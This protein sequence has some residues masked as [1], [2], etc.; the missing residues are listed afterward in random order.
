MF[1]CLH[2]EAPPYLVEL[3]QPVAGVASRQHIRSATRQLLVVPRH[4]L[5]FYG[6]RTFCVAGLSVWNSPPDSLRNPFIIGG[7]SFRQSLKTFLFTTYWYIQRNRGFTTICY[8]NLLFLLTY[9]DENGF[10]VFNGGWNDLLSI[11]SD[12]TKNYRVFRQRAKSRPAVVERP[13]DASRL[14]VVSFNSTIPRAQSSII[15]Y[16]GFRFTYAYN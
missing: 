6:R 10:C 2:G 14:S 3:Y 1:N 12:T 16:C 13:R 11:S 4:R 8:I 9:L 15:S 5:S 7:N